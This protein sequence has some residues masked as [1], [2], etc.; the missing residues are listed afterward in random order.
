MRI[1]VE[2]IL[3]NNNW[4]DDEFEKAQDTDNHFYITMDMISD[5]IHQN[6]SLNEGDFVSEITN[7]KREN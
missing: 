1:K 3:D 6:V 2:Y 4:S 5:L 7:I